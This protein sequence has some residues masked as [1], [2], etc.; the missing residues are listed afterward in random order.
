MQRRRSRQPPKHLSQTLAHRRTLCS[1]QALAGPQSS[2]LGTSEQAQPLQ[3]CRALQR[4]HKRRLRKVTSL[5]VH[6]AAQPLQRQTQPT[7][8]ESA[9]PTAVQLLDRP[10]LHQMVC[11]G[12][13]AA[14][15]SSAPPRSHARSGPSHAPGKQAMDPA[16]LRLEERRVWVAWQVYATCAMGQR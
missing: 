12:R 15:A 13:H 2:T 1:C 4:R 9:A 8:R 5:S 10:L 3:P 6:G 16:A 11:P 7:H 14:V